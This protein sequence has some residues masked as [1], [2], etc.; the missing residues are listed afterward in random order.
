MLVIDRV[1]D[2]ITGYHLLPLWKFG[3]EVYEI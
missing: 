2:G 1:D 3:I